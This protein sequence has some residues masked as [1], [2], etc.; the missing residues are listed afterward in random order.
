LRR[1]AH[2]FK[3]EAGT[4]GATGVAAFC[5]ELET[6]PT[7]LDRAGAAGV[8]ARAEQEIVRVRHRLEAELGRAQVS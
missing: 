4:L 5:A 3:G 2:R 8:L 6:M 1:E 7:P